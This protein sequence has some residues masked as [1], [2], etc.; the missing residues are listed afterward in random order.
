MPALASDTIRFECPTLFVG[1]TGYVDYENAKIHGVSLITGDLVAEGHGLFCDDILLKQLHALGK[2]MGQIP[3]TLDHGGGIKSVNGF[4]DNVRLDTVSKKWRGDW[5]LL[6]THNETETMLE[7]ADRQASTFGM[8]C[9]FKGPPKGV[10]YMGRKCARAEKL[11]SV[12]CVTRAAANPDG[13]FSSRD[14]TIDLNTI[15]DAI[16]ALSNGEPVDNSHKH[17]MANNSQAQEPTLAQI[18]AAVQG[19]GER[20]EAFEANQAALAE[21]I[22]AGPQAGN[23]NAELDPDVLAQFN[24]MNP[25]Q[26][27]AYNRANGTQITR[28]DIDNAI[29]QWNASVEAGEAEGGEEGEVEGAEGYDG[30]EVEGAQGGGQ[31]A[32]AATGGGETS[33]AFSALA[34]QVTQLTS[35]IKAR[36]LAEREQAEQHQFQAIEHNFE[37]LAQERNQ[38]IQFSEQLVAENE[39]LRLCIRTGTRPVKGGNNGG[40]RMFSAGVDGNLHEFQE[41]IQGLMDEKKVKSLGEAIQFASKENPALHR[42]WLLWQ[43]DNRTTLRA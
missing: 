13:M 19:M 25:A 1:Q 41:R 35:R 17:Q 7:R 42:D 14:N 32:G 33:A 28:A 3:V 16:V 12:D 8:S 27:A 22:E 4:I 43:R 2:D 29:D 31:M 5:S 36:E 24:Q 6:K 11:L 37:A 34:R 15:Y 9:S 10:L 21:Q 26:L 23:E 18:L 30:G 39:A 40:D 38:L 20:M